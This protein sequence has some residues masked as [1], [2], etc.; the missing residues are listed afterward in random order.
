M[1]MIGLIIWY[2]SIVIALCAL[3]DFHKMI[4]RKFNVYRDPNSSKDITRVEREFVERHVKILEVHQLKISEMKRP[5]I[6]GQWS[7]VPLFF[8]LMAAI[9]VIFMLTPNFSD[10]LIQSF[11]LKSTTSNPLVVPYPNIL[12]FAMAL[13]LSLAGIVPALRFLFIRKNTKNFSFLLLLPSH[14]IK[15]QTEEYTTAIKDIRKNLAKV[16][17][18]LIQEDSISSVNNYSLQELLKILTKKESGFRKRIGLASL[19]LMFL[20]YIMSAFEFVKVTSGEIVY[21]PPYSFEIIRRPL[22]SV[23]STT[24]LCK[25]DDNDRYLKLKVKLDDGFEFSV[26]RIEFNNL[27]APLKASNIEL[28]DLDAASDWCKNLD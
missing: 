26:R 12:T 21:S 14:E 19:S 27:D 10:W 9:L 13:M 22:D 11:T 7:I 15:P 18:S 23:E 2:L 1:A 16:L 3:F 5:S 24:Y 8:I 4:L 6:L 20:G 25:R 17:S 28:K